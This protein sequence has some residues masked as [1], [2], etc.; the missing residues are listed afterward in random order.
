MPHADVGPIKIENSDLTVD[1]VLFLSDALPPGFY[2][3]DVCDIK[4]GDVVAVWGAG[5]VGL[6]AMA[7]AKM[8]GAERVKSAVAQTAGAGLLNRRAQ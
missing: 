3:A 5:A 1:Q 7:S 2:G 8:L 4:P 6:F